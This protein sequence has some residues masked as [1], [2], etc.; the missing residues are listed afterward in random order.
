MGASLG[1]LGMV[2]DLNVFTSILALT[3]ARGAAGLV[4]TLFWKPI[5]VSS[6]GPSS[7]PSSKNWSSYRGRSPEPLEGF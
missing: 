6:A 2:D 1:W 5:E 4:D 7:Q 3:E